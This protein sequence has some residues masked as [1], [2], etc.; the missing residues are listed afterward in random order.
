MEAL[1]KSVGRVEETALRAAS[2][3]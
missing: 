2:Q 1:Q 3:Q